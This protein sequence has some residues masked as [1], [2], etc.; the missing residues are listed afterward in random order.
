LNGRANDRRAPAGSS[1][2][3]LSGLDE[4]LLAVGCFVSVIC[5]AKER[6][7]DGEG[8]GLVEDNAEGNSRRLDGR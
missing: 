1:G 3:S 6:G 7:E 2:G 8:G 4:L 5:I